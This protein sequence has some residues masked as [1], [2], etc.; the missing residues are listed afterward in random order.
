MQPKIKIFEQSLSREFAAV[1]MAVV[2]V[3]IAIIVTEQIV[4]FLGKAASGS[5]EP[6]AVTV[7]LGFWL[8][9]YL[10]VVLALSLF[11]SILMTMSRS[12]RDSEMAVWFASGQPITAWIRPVLRFALPIVGV[13]A[14][15]S[16]FL[17]PWAYTQQAEYQR[18]LRSKDDVSR[19]SPGSFIEARSANQVFFIDNTSVGTDVINNVFVQDNRNGRYRVIAAEKGFQQIDPNG[20]K[21]MVLVNGREYE[22]TPG[23]ADFRIVDFERERI[24]IDTRAV[25]SEEPDSRQLSTVELL[26]RMVVE[27]DSP[28]P[29]QADQP[30]PNA[31]RW[32]ELH[33]RVSLPLAALVL[34][35]IAVPLSFVNPRSGSAWNL[36]LASLLFALYYYVLRVA[37]HWT[38]AGQLPGWLGLAP[39]HL[40]MVVTVV[41]LFFKQMFSFRWLVSA[42]K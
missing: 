30:P 24:R 2:S 12:Y 28:A 15:L 1:G 31:E 6:E 36:I 19:L 13:T 23:A 42:Q 38:A 22:G 39:V 33:W 37:E 20:D 27:G 7:L 26:R 8:L 29:I 5:I 10:P 17:T 41:V 25:A 16:L 34:A 11:I 3:L 9:I 18:I 32:A 14:L 21:F 4:V 40:F 35:L